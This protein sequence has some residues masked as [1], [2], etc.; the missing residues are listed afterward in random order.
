M[1]HQAILDA[2]K[3]L[4]HEQRTL[5][6]PCCGHTESLADVAA[7][8]EW[9]SDPH[10]TMAELQECDWVCPECGAETSSEIIP[11]IENLLTNPDLVWS[12]G[13]RAISVAEL[14]K[15]IEPHRHL[16]W[17]RQKQSLPV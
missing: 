11:T 14:I 5:L 13:D 2:I 4:P 1:D 8:L 7:E 17:A 15:L 10:E 3:Q 6:C 12:L 9:G 16:L